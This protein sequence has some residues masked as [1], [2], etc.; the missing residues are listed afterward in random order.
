MGERGILRIAAKKLVNVLSRDDT[1]VWKW[2]ANLNKE[3]Q[4]AAPI[5]RSNQPVDDLAAGLEAR[6]SGCDEAE[7]GVGHKPFNLFLD[8]CPSSR[9]RRGGR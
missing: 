1:A 5:A 7:I 4:N 9:R 6:H 8:F 2:T 3:A